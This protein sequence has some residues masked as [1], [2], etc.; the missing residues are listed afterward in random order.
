MEN[1]ITP[2]ITQT[3]IAAKKRIN[4][5]TLV[6]FI[7]LILVLYF[8]SANARWQN[9]ANNLEQKLSERVTPAPARPTPIPTPEVSKSYQTADIFGGEMTLHYPD[10]WQYKS[11]DGIN[12]ISSTPLTCSD[13]RC[14]YSL[15]HVDFSDK[16]TYVLELSDYH[17]LPTGTSKSA[18]Y[19]K[20]KE[21]IAELDFEETRCKKEKPCL[22]TVPGYVENYKALPIFLFPD[23][24]SGVEINDFPFFI[25]ENSTARSYFVVYKDRTFKI[26]IVY[27]KALEVDGELTEMPRPFN[28]ILSKLEVK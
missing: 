8:I 11:E 28:E 13:D 24:M 20:L 17:R 1:Q 9:Y 4:W 27:P 2:P 23:G 3:P 14:D 25:P 12:Y 15:Y 26:A 16:N 21:W 19:Y 5:W 10:N 18:L 22:P 6:F 7:E